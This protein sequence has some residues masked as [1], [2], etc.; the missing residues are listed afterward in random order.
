MLKRKFLATLIIG[1]IAVPS[2][3]LTAFAT[4]H[5][6]SSPERANALS[7]RASFVTC[8]CYTTTSS[9]IRGETKTS[10][11]SAQNSDMPSTAQ[12]NPANSFVPVCV[13]HE[14]STPTANQSSTCR[15]HSRNYQ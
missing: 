1:V 4:Q 9:N 6:F 12:V 13:R 5:E 10:Y 14:V 3:I 8:S 15:L 7:T 2:L 11:K